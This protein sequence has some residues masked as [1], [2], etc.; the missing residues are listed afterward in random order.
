[1]R[2]TVLGGLAL[3]PST[4]TRPKP[5]LLLAYL[6]LGGPRSRRDVAELFWQGSK[7]P[8]QGL[9]MALL[10]LNKE[11]P[12][13]I[14][15]DEKRVWTNLKSDL[16]DLREHLEKNDLETALTFYQ[17]S[18]AEGFDMQ[19]VGEE[20]EEWI[21]KTRERVA[22]EVQ[23]ALLELAEKAA[24]DANYSGAASRAEEAYLLRFAP[25]PDSDTLRRIYTLLRTDENSQAESVAKE[26]KSY[27][28]ELNLSPEAARQ[29]FLKTT[30]PR[31]RATDF[32]GSETPAL[33]VQVTPP[34]VSMAA[35]KTTPKR[36]W[37]ILPLLPWLLVLVLLTLGLSFFSLR[38]AETRF[39]ARD[40]SDDADVALNYGNNY[41]C[42]EHPN[43]YL[44][45]SYEGQSTALRFRNVGIPKGKE[46]T[47]TSALLLFTANAHIPEVPGGSGFTVR[48][49]FDASPWLPM[50]CG[51]NLSAAGNNY[52]ARARTN[53][54]TVYRPD[55]WI[56]TQ[57]YSVDVTN[58]VQEIVDSPDWTSEDMA[59]AINKLTTS[60]A[61]LKAYSNEGGI[62]M[63]D[64][65]K[66]PQFVVTFTTK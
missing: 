41:F 40:S 26:A 36:N 39:P 9:R 25:E 58:I 8:M 47:V 29:Q 45:S 34:E 50:L 10:Q 66:Q 61:D 13:V 33:P 5:L 30:T 48:G 38:P 4:F 18:F 24:A 56:V 65:G 51:Q 11:A 37:R 15:T 60:S 31:R 43:L 20:L 2:L 57:Q 12:D 64:L 3:E 6:S 46:I 16:S 55:T 42:A 32:P 22:D 44:S 54:V 35:N 23:G 53:A 49:L 14:Q 1:M 21:F 28:L 52:V 17:G 62:L 27:R 59:F 7:D 19:D 63:K